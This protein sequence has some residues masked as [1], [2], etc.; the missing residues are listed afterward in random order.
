M[1]TR[2]TPAIAFVARSRDAAGVRVAQAQRLPPGHRVGDDGGWRNAIGIGAI[3]ELAIRIIACT[4]GEFLRV[5]KLILLAA[6]GSSDL[7][8]HA[9]L[10]AFPGGQGQIVRTRLTPAIAFVARSRDAAG[11]TVASAQ[12]LPPGHRVGDDGVGKN[13]SCVGA[14]AKVAIPII[15]CKGGERCKGY[16]ADGPA[17]DPT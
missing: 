12:R 2:L 5:I 1:R 10:F 16:T 11:V 8:I 17:A 13:I 9:H 15:A 4:G 3:A 14:D 7:S 6:L